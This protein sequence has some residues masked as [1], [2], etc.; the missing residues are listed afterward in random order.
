MEKCL[1]AE[2]G[3]LRALAAS[4]SEGA[5]LPASTWLTGGN[6]GVRVIRLLA[7][8]MEEVTAVVTLGRRRQVKAA[9][10]GDEGGGEGRAGG[11][12][13]FGG[14]SDVFGCGSSRNFP[15]FKF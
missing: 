8:G 11:E 12:A 15:Q 3:R 14:G 4:R 13:H 10:A 6:G 7:G 5:G 2:M 9:S 1:E